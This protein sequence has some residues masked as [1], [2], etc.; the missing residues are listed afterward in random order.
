MPSFSDASR[1]RLETCDPRLQ[2]IFNEVIKHVD[3]TVLCGTRSEEEQEEAFRT[4]KSKV[5][6][7]NSKHNSNPSLAV[8]VAPYPVDWNDLRSFIHFSGFVRG[9]ASQ[10][11]INI[12]CGVDWNGNYSLKD[13]NFLDAPHFEL[14]D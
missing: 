3:C 4:G 9:I 8:D 10:M 1:Q 14:V 2:K 5:H 7:P 6:Y 11:G 13:E 12:R